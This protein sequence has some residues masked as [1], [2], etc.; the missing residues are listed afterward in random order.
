M[1][2]ETHAPGIRHYPQY[3]VALVE[4]LLSTPGSWL[5]QVRFCYSNG[6]LDNFDS[7]R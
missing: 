3:L 2:R 1:T 6:D 4:F 5:P 7:Y